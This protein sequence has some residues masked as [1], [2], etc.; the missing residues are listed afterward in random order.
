MSNDFETLEAMPLLVTADIAAKVKPI[1][2]K[3]DLRHI[4]LFGSYA[5]GDANAESDFDFIIDPGYARGLGLIGIF[6][7]FEAIFGKD[8]VDL[9]TMDA[10]DDDDF[11][12]MQAKKD[13]VLIYAK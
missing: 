4:F 1:A 3:H 10:L 7:D 2:E 5:R 9:L 8:R 12:L 13:R 6:R 11:F